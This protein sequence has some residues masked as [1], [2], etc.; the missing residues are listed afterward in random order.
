MASP[1]PRRYG[2]ASVCA[3]ASACPRPSELSATF[4]YRQTGIEVES[5]IYS[6][7][8]M[9]SAFASRR[10]C[11]LRGDTAAMVVLARGG[12]EVA[13]WPLAVSGGLD[14][15]AVDELAQLQLAA[16]RL[17]CSIRLRDPCAELLDLLELV[18]LADLV[19]GACGP[20]IRRRLQGQ[21]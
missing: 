1:S 9:S 4:H 8:S 2:T 18:G 19:N 11:V 5:D 6:S 12:V 16:R 21:P 7:V 15:G 3:A 17:G 13:S 14:L 20:A 10:S